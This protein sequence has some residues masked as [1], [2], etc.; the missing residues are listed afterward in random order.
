MKGSLTAGMVNTSITGGS[1]KI[2]MRMSRHASPL[3][4]PMRVPA[5]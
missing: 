1:A 3:L 5:E 2:D 4:P